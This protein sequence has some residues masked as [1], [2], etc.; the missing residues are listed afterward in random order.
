MYQNPENCR[1]GAG[2]CGRCC[3][4]PRGS[5]W[6]TPQLKD[7]HP[8]PAR[9]QGRGGWGPRWQ[10][11]EP[12]S[13]AGLL[14][15]L[16]VQLALRSVPLTSCCQPALPG[17]VRGHCL[18]PQLPGQNLPP[19]SSLFQNMPCSFHP[20]LPTWHLPVTSGHTCLGPSALPHLG[21]PGPSGRGQVGSQLG[22]GELPATLGTC[23]SGRLLEDCRGCC[24]TAPPCRPPLRPGTR[25]TLFQLR[26]WDSLGGCSCGWV[27]IASARARTSTGSSHP[28]PIL[29]SFPQPQDSEL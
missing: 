25:L 5:R 3:P 20:S 22:P 15:P 14:G 10:S 1:E 13:C 12:P 17:A 4:T 7:S 27:P 9:V 24:P 2:E 23:V 11:A 28:G 8:R 26:L 29:A 16:Y 18:C 21:V 6:R 19:A